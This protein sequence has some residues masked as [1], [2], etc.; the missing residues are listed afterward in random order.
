MADEDD[1]EDHHVEAAPLPDGPESPPRTRPNNEPL[2]HCEQDL[3]ITYN[4]ISDDLLERQRD[5]QAAALWVACFKGDVRALDKLLRSKSITVDF[6]NDRGMTGFA[7]CCQKGHLEQLKKLYDR[8]SLGVEINGLDDN[9][10]TP[11]FHACAGGQLEV[12]KW[13]ADLPETQAYHENRN[14]ETALHAAV[15]YGRVEVVR[16]LLTTPINGTFTKK[17]YFRLKPFPEYLRRRIGP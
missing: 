9:G 17:M 1:F 3:L 8:K 10:A 4:A 7:T 2:F 15:R 14:N 16:Y 13:L 5:R 6:V 12:V 11:L